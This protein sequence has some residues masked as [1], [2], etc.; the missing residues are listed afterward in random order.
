VGSGT[1]SQII[2]SLNKANLTPQER[3][4]V[5]SN[6]AA[7]E[8]V[9]ALR[10]SAGG[11]ATDTAVEKLDAL[12]PNGTTP[13]IDYLLKQTGQIRQTAGRLGKGVTT[14]QGGLKLPSEGGVADSAPLGTTSKP[15]GVYEM[16]GKSYR[17]QGGKVYA[18]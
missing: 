16:N 5:T 8:N 9:Q 7:H 10:K 13:D 15:D 1:P 3:D 12:L 11:T 2:E 4:Y 6:L 14:V 17:V 18:H